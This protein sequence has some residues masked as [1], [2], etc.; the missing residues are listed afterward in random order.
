MKKKSLTKSYQTSNQSRPPSKW[1]IQIFIFRL[2]TII[3]SCSSW[4]S[5]GASLVRWRCRLEKQKRCDPNQRPG[6]NLNIELWTADRRL[7][8]VQLYLSQHWLP[9]A[10]D[11]I[12]TVTNHNH[13]KL[14][15]NFNYIIQS[16]QTKKTKNIW[17]FKWKLSLYI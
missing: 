4:R 6:I 2:Q 3:I 11:E 9:V 1:R 10:T 5:W 16:F 12:I 14:R 7:I 15:R 8:F 17:L 13:P